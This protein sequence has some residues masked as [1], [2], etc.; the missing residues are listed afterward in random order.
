MQIIVNKRGKIYK[1]G[2]TSWSC[3]AQGINEN[4]HTISL[5]P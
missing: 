3:S 5:Q 2:S 1:A 4:D